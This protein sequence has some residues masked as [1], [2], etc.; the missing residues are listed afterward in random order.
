MKN[1]VKN[2]KKNIRYNGYNLNKTAEFTWKKEKYTLYED[3]EETLF[4]DERYVFKIE[5]NAPFYVGTASVMANHIMQNIE[6][7]QYHKLPK[8]ILEAI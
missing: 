3:P 1:T 4:T 2:M 8:A 6:D 5:D 7:P